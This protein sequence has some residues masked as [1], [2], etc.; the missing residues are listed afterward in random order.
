ML[1]RIKVLF[2]GLF[3]GKGSVRAVWKLIYS[4]VGYIS[5][6]IAFS[7]LI[8][9]VFSSDVI[10]ILC[11]NHY[12]ILATIGI[13]ASLIHNRDKVYC[14]GFQKGSDFKI[15][16]LV[17]DLFSSNASSYVIPTNTFFRTKLDGDYISSQSV[18]G[19]F[20]LKYY[21]KNIEEL[22]NLIAKSLTHQGIAGTDDIDIYGAVKKYPIGTVA[23]VDCKRKHFYFVAVNDVNKYGKPVKQDYANVD[24][25]L[26][27]LLNA[28]RC[29]GNCDDLA[30]PL[31]G[32]G[33]AAIR[34]ATIEKVF[35]DTLDKFL[36]SSDKISRKLVICIRPI[37]YL[38]G[39]ADINRIDKY[40]QYGC[41][42]AE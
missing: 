40:L 22:E 5:S 4:A 23:K 39:R 12:C 20:Q 17:S 6:I 29:F 1:D 9:E 32:T 7:L 38:E 27:G 11:R 33:R 10:L 41:E 24:V 21:R 42:F 26:D 2:C 37:D 8:K 28:I 31:I 25:A 34:E 18:Q 3:R 30:M 36:L 35:K 15:E 13:I 14:E 19:A 16:V